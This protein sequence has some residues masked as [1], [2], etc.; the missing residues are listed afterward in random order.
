VRG[1][2]EDG[3]GWRERG[4]L[5]RGDWTIIALAHTTISA[6]ISPARSGR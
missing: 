1:R 5:V 2:G 4:G 3:D 6:V